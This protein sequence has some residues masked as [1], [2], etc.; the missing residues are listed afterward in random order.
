MGN[1]ALQSKVKGII[2]GVDGTLLDSNDAHALAWVEA[3]SWGGAFANFKSVRP[4]I[5]MGGDKLLPAVTGLSEE[6]EKGKRISDKRGEVF[7]EKFLP[8]LKVFTGTYELLDK[9]TEIGFPM[10]IA[11][12]ASKAD[13]KDLLKIG[14]LEKYFSEKTSADDADHSKP[15]PDIVLSAARKLGIPPADLMMIGDTPYDIEAAGQLSIPTL[16]FLCGGSD[17]TQ[18][19]KALAIYE[20]PEDLFK[21]LEDSPLGITSSGEIEL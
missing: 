16:A 20:G 13:L 11:S 4:L 9:L 15:D 1:V 14:G 21:H 17:P 12:S 3:I 8:H 2:F 5:G 7:R 10:A 6:S 19:S 18:L